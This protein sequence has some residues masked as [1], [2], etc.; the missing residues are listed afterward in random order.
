METTQF[1]RV[2][3]NIVEQLKASGDYADYEQLPFTKAQNWDELFDVICHNVKRCNDLGILLPDG[4]YKKFKKEFTIENGKLHG[5]YVHFY[6]DGKMM[7][8]D[9]YVHG[10]KHGECFLYYENGKVAEKYTYLNGQLDTSNFLDVKLAIKKKIIELTQTLKFDNVLIKHIEHAQNWDMIKL[11][12]F[13]NVIWCN[14]N[15]VPMPDGHY[16]NK[17]T[18]FT[19]LNGKLNGEFFNYWGN[20]Q[21]W[22]KYTYVDG[23]K[24]G[25]YLKYDKDGNVIEKRNYVHGER[26]KTEC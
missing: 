8:K 16:C 13:D 11:F 14:K 10:K 9:F 1:L 2:Q 21:V 6:D 17:M 22:E 18:E 15:G 26:V 24:H 23:K 25:E 20:G 5:E 3:K 7:L 4:H 19:I 12:V